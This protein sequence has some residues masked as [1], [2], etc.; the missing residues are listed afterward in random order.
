M[1]AIV[2]TFLAMSPVDPAAAAPVDRTRVNA[3]KFKPH[4]YSVKCVLS[5][6]AASHVKLWNVFPEFGVR[7]GWLLL[8]PESDTLIVRVT[9]A[10]SDRRAGQLAAQARSGNQIYPGVNAG[11]R[12]V[13]KRNVLIGYRGRT[14]EER[15]VKDAVHRFLA[16]PC[17]Q[18]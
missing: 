9:L 4:P 16:S 17:D 18:T 3:A 12:F 7:Y 6:F 14:R 10:A 2:V 11:F 13:V 8:Q 1:T 15:L 5:T